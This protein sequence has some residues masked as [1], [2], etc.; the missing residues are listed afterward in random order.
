MKQP[1]VLITLIVFIAGVS[2]VLSAQEQ[3]GGRPISAI[4]SGGAEVPGPGDADGTG[5]VKLTFNPGQN[6]ICYELTVENIAP[7][8]MAHIHSGA[9]NAAGPVVV[10]LKAPTQGTVKDCVQVDKDKISKIMD[11][12]ES[13]YVNVHN[14]DF[15]N[16]AVRGQLPK[17][18]S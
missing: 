2:F 18:G 6:Q 16:G 8:T 12:P 17:Q 3:K 9:A 14:A 1:G 13:F 4:L 10:T 15:P 5:L 7:A 11:D